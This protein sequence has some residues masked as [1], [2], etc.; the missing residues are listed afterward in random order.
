MIGKG[1]YDDVCTAARE[2]TAAR[3]VVLIVFDGRQG[4]GFS[5]QADAFVLG[6]LPEVLEDLA[7]Q[8]RRDL[9]GMFTTDPA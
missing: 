6:M 8:I 7:R 3:G 4:H 1:I 2:S 5:V 9:P